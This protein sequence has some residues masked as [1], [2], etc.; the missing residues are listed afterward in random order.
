MTATGQTFLCVLLMLQDNWGRYYRTC[1]QLTTMQRGS[2]SHYRGM[3]SRHAPRSVDAV[4]IGVFVRKEITLKE[5][6]SISW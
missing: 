2:E 6:F 3:A 5:I 1:P 4:E